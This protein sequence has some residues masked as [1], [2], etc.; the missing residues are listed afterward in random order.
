MQLPQNKRVDVTCQRKKEYC[1][2]YSNASSFDLL[3]GCVW[4]VTWKKKTHT[5]TVQYRYVRMHSAVLNDYSV[6]YDYSLYSWL[7]SVVS[8]TESLMMLCI[9]NVWELLS[10]CVKLGGHSCK[11]P[12]TVCILLYLTSQSKFTALLTP[13][14][15]TL[16]SAELYVMYL[17]CYCN[18][19]IRVY[20]SASCIVKNTSCLEVKVEAHVWRKC[21]KSYCLLLHHHLEHVTILP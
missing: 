5:G 11:E 7:D 13:Y 19:V 14:C 8:G 21:Y 16:L 10:L 17:E 18:R 20:T 2:L 3:K 4:K 6:Q 12:L 9:R 1:N 15:T